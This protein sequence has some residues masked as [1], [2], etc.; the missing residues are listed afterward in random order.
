VRLHSNRHP[1]LLPLRRSALA[2]LAAARP[3]RRLVL[4]VMTDGLPRLRPRRS[5]ASLAPW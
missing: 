3:L 4:G 1:L 5:L 2:L